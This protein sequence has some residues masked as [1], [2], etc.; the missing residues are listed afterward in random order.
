MGR[1]IPASVLCSTARNPPITTSLNWAKKD[2]TEE[3][4][5]C[6]KAAAVYNDVKGGVDYF[7]L[8]KE[9]YQIKRSVKPWHRILYFLIDLSNIN[10]FI[11]WQVNKR[12]RSLEQLTSLQP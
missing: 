8:R 6:P 2:G 7:Y 10:S 12:N 4:V 1:Q 5:P 3:E 11:Q 9:R